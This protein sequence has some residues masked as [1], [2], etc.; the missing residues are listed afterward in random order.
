MV[1]TVM[2]EK[3]VKY[4]FLDPE[5]CIFENCTVC[6]R[7]PRGYG[8]HIASVAKLVADFNVTTKYLKICSPIV[9]GINC[10]V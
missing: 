1:P 7:K 3:I 2:C 4:A 8:E 6:H 5:L 9:W 10:N